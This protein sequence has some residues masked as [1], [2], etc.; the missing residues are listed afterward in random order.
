MNKKHIKIRFDDFWKGGLNPYTTIIY[1]I[2]SKRYDVEIVEDGYDVEYLVYSVYRDN[3]LYYPNNVIKIC[4]SDEDLT[5]D[6]NLCDYGIAFDWMEYGDR[7]FRLPYCYFHD[8]VIKATLLMEKK[9]LNLD[10]TSKFINRRFCSFVVSNAWG[11][12]I[13]KEFYDLLDQYKIIDSGG[14]WRNNV[15]GPVPD[16]LEFDKNHKFSICFE[17]S[18]HTGY[19]TEKLVDGFA[20]QTIPIYWG[21]PDVGRVFNKKSFI[22]VHDFESLVDVV[23]EVERLDND[24]DAYMEMLRQPALLSE[25]WTYDSVKMRL[26]LFLYNIFDQDLEEAKRHTRIMWNDNYIKKRQESFEYYNLR[27][28]K[29]FAKKIKDRIRKLF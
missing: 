22:C 7:Y 18:S 1:D 17:N 26:E 24:D 3:N 21:D 11:D 23:K 19:T 28:K 15:G 8:D 20:A 4:Y 12:P 2:L 16:K 27:W 25:D 9:S 6:F 14:R 13:R 5:P 29:F 10:D